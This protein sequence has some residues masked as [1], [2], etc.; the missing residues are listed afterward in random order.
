MLYQHSSSGGS[1]QSPD[2]ARAL[3][4]KCP[5]RHLCV[6]WKVQVLQDHC[7]WR[8]F[9]RRMQ[10][11]AEEEVGVLPTLVLPNSMPNFPPES[12]PP[13]PAPGAWL[14]AHRRGT[15]HREARASPGPFHQ[16][17]VR[18][19]LQLLDAPDFLEGLFH[20]HLSSQ[21]SAFPAPPSTASG[22]VPEIYSLS[23]NRATL[24][25]HRTSGLTYSD[26]NSLIGLQSSRELLQ[27]GR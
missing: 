1:P 26:G 23:H 18:A 13:G 7:S 22:L 25:S 17:P 19:S 4:Q 20:L 14:Q 21:T 8:S 6:P 10:W 12:F 27:N 5:K 11:W 16:P 9:H 3:I 2:F 15:P 24:L